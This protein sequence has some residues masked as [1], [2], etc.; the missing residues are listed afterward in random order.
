MNKTKNLS[1]YKNQRFSIII[2]PLELESEKFYIAYARELGKGSCYGEGEN[3]E[4][5]LE[6]FYHAKDEFLDL[7]YSMDKP[8]PEPQ[9]EE[10]DLPSGT[11]NLRTSPQ[12]HAKLIRQA[13]G[14]K[15][16]LNAYLN[17]VISSASVLIDV[18]DALLKRLSE[19]ESNLS[20]DHQRINE[21]VKSY[22][23]EKEPSEL[24]QDMGIFIVHTKTTPVPGWI[25]VGKAN[26]SE[27]YKLFGSPLGREH[28]EKEKVI[29]R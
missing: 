8:I 21:S 25:N 10:E 16:S 3:P 26:L 9:F 12:I 14:S 18:R 13:K 7:L 24:E 28:E 5:A 17:Q 2:E 6:N 20:Y 27:A 23:W 11:I 19:L 1:F 22:Y 15:C 4:K 29:D